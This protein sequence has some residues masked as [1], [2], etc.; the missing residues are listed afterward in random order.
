M[1][2]NLTE[3]KPLGLLFIRFAFPILLSMLFQQF[4]NLIDTM[5]VGRSLGAEALAAVGSTGALNFM[6]IGFLQRR[7]RRVRHSH[8]TGLWWGKKKMP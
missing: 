8:G 2:K 3:G 6:I 7:L 5:I 4:Y 1:T